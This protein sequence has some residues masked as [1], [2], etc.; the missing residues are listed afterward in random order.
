EEVEI[1]ENGKKQQISNFSFVSNVR[2]RT[3]QEPSEKV[4]RNAPLL[5]TSPIKQENVRRTVALVVDDLTLS[6]EST[7]HVRRAL[8][9][10]V[11]EEMQDGDLVAIIRAG[12]GIG[13]LQQ[14]TADKRMLYAAIEKV[15]WNPT[16]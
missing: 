9:K 16:A 6:F 2:E 11:D 5:P 1:Y 3:Q 12:A 14:F 15:K 10:F 4:D 13:A 7:Y 8:R